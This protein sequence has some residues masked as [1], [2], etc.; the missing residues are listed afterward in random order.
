MCFSEQGKLDE[1]RK[2]HEQALEIQ[3]RVLGPEHPDTLGSM[4]ALA[5]VLSAQGK[6]DEARKLDEQDA[7]DPDAAPW[8]RSIPTRWG[9]CTTWQALLRQQGKMDEAR[10]LRKLHEQTSGDP[11]PHAWVRS[12][13]DTLRSMHNLADVLQSTG[14]DGRGPQA[15]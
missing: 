10:K 4:E 8:V 9:R 15:A 14:Q 11:T 13:P 7:G 1:A 5:Q 12:I 2:L 6:I 3:R